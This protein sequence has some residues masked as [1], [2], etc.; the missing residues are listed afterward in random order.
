MADI[1]TPIAALRERLTQLLADWGAEMSMVLKDLEDSRAR[2][3]GLEERSQGSEGEL[4]SLKRRV[5]GQEELIETLR[6]DAEEAGALRKSLYDAE[7]EAEKYRAELES[8]RDLIKALRKDANRADELKSELKR[9]EDALEL[10]GNVRADLEHRLA[11]A[12]ER[13]SAAEDTVADS[14]DDTTELVAVRAE[15][16][17]K[18]SLLQSIRNDADRCEALE[19]R[20]D[21]KRTTI[22]KLEAS[23][24]SQAATIAELTQ[25]VRRWKEKY[26]S[27]KGVDVTNDTVLRTIPGLPIGEMGDVEIDQNAATITDQLAERT[28]AINMRDS[29]REARDALDKNKTS[30]SGKPSK[31]KAAKA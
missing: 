27:A 4:E 13:L 12:N 8:K 18:T 21:E 25:S 29:L 6:N 26:A 16:A 5:S 17:A 7:I 10:L 23:L 31:G 14:Q 15:L 20:L 24:D 2:V 19:E 28:V 11:E 9:K 22:A 1:D 30:N 3:A